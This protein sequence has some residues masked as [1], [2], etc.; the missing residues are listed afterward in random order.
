MGLARRGLG[1]ENIRRFW[2]RIWARLD[3]CR[4][5]SH[6]R[7]LG[8]GRSIA[9]YYPSWQDA[10]R[11]L[12]CSGRRWLIGATRRVDPASQVL[13]LFVHCMER[14]ILQGYGCVCGAL[15]NRLSQMLHAG[16]RFRSQ[17]RSARQLI[18]GRACGRHVRI[19]V[20]QQIQ[21]QCGVNALDGDRIPRRGGRLGRIID[22]DDSPQQTGAEVIR[23]DRHRPLS[24]GKLDH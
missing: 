14:G 2:R 1:W 22:L 20:V 10:A 17:R 9:G 16:H 21:F 19:G 13:H 6:D 5:I 15:L 11:R 24:A 7:S 3:D 4:Q 12:I 23:H 8:D 18:I